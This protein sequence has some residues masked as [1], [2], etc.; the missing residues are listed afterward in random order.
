VKSPNLLDLQLRNLFGPGPDDGSAGRVGLLGEQKCPLLAAAQCLPQNVNHEFEGMVVII[1]QD[2]VVGRY[3]PR[4]RPLLGPG[5]YH[6]FR[7]SCCI[8]HGPT[9]KR[10]VFVI[11]SLFYSPR[12]ELSKQEQ[13]TFKKQRVKLME[14]VKQ[15]AKPSF[16]SRGRLEWFGRV[17]GLG[18]ESLLR[19]QRR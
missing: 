2:H 8:A 17:N 16:R 10:F 19:A 9:L 11:G 5:P 12:T 18:W 3:A 4:L 1:F 7:K 15:A 14:K 13:A 6:H